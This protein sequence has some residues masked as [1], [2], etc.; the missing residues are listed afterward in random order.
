MLDGLSIQLTVGAPGY[1]A[2]Q[3]RRVATSAA[4]TL[5]GMRA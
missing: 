4:R 1:S 2:D 5:L 3:I